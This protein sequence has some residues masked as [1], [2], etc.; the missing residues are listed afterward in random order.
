MMRI[1]ALTIFA[2]LHGRFAPMVANLGDRLRGFAQF[3]SGKDGKLGVLRLT[4]AADRR[5][6]ELSRD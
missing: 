1:L 6:Y 2:A 5:A 3:E 4:Y